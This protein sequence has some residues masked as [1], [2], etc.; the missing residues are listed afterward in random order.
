MSK[1]VLIPKAQFFK[2]QVTRSNHNIGLD[3]ARA[4]SIMGIFIAHTNNYSGAFT[5]AYNILGSLSYL[6]QELFFALS[7]FL[8]GNQIIKYINESKSHYGLLNFYKNRWIRTVPFYLIFLL[9]N[10]LIFQFIY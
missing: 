8:V 7:G 2:T 1:D 5:S 6:M 9:I 3:I 4:I 10:F